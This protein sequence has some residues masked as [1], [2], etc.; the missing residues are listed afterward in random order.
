VTRVR[1]A[2]ASFVS[3]F[4]AVVVAAAV[5]FLGLCHSGRLTIVWWLQN[6]IFICTYR[7]SESRRRGCHGARASVARAGDRHDGPTSWTSLRLD[8]LDHVALA[9]KFPDTKRPSYATQK[10]RGPETQAVAGH[11]IEG[12]IRR[13]CTILPPGS[14]AT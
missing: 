11:L 9:L 10:L 6:A 1:R 3:K 13:D 7:N 14:I 12:I 4:M 8:Q 5:E 2:F